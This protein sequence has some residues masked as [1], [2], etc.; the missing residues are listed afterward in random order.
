MTDLI[1]SAPTPQA[2]ATDQVF[3][4][5]YRAIVSLDLP[6]GAKISEVEV[7]GRFDVSRQPVRD[8]FF[9]LSKLGFLAIRPQRATR[10]TKISERAV[11]DAAFV[12]TALE[13][14]CFRLALDLVTAEQMAELR[15]LLEAQQAAVSRDARAEF[16]DLDDAFHRRICEIAGHGH[17]WTLIREQKAHM[18]RVRFLS[19]SQ[20]GQLALDEHVHILDAIEAGDAAQT[21]AWVRKHL[22]RILT[23][24]S[25]IRE[26]HGPY[27]EDEG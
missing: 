22:G 10:V 21:D 27:F 6:P 8:A 1:L 17:A 18:D 24:V 13:T 5:V 4:A 12:R 23:F 26:K 16:H 15:A 25:H 14:A 9:R 3:D 19:L 7:A 11:R 20:D 2:S